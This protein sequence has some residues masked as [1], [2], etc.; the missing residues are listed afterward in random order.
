M[1]IE[2]NPY[3]AP[4]SAVE[5]DTGEFGEPT[6]FSFKSRAGRLRYLARTMIGTFVA[7]LVFFF[8]AMVVGAFVAVGGAS[9]EEV[10]ELVVP[11]LMIPMLVVGLGMLV[12]TCMLGMQRLH[13]LDLSGWWYLLMFVPLVNLIFAI[14]LVFAPGTK[15]ANRYGMPP[16][17][18][19]FGIKLTVW[20]VIVIWAVGVV[21]L[22]TVGMQAYYD[23][24]ARVEQLQQQQ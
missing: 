6:I 16:P 9:P 13:D 20:I 15:G 4:A 17:P 24:A 22:G 21:V 19:T 10:E 7:Y 8:V 14:Y 11:A 5:Q 2:V 23:Y 1:A 3:A 12:V 18:N